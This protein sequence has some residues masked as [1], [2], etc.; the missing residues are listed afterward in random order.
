MS[1]NFW[2]QML[3]NTLLYDAIHQ[4]RVVRQNQH[5]K[6]LDSKIEMCDF[7]RLTLPSGCSSQY[8]YICNKLLL[9]VET[10]DGSISS[11]ESKYEVLETQE[12]HAGKKNHNIL[13]KMSLKEHLIRCYFKA[14]Y[15]FSKKPA[16]FIAVLA[17]M[18]LTHDI[19]KIPKISAQYK[20]KEALSHNEISGRWI[21]DFFKEDIATQQISHE[22]ITLIAS[23][24]G[25]QHYHKHE[26]LDN[27]SKI[28]QITTE[29]LA[30]LR[31]VDEAAR[32]EEISILQD[33]NAKEGSNDC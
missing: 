27:P 6:L 28:K 26:K 29:Y 15:M 18:A 16:D 30:C 14:V 10:I 5:K 24:V 9:F 12:S 31:V 32:S 23:T 2:E 1:I 4:K 33:K 17:A 7:I 21:L 20:Q 19:G 25:A 3:A 8:K 13:M 22:I 11:V